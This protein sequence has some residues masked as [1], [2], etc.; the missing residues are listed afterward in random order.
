MNLFCEIGLIVI[1]LLLLLLL[2]L[3][4]FYCTCMFCTSLISYK[5]RTIM[6]INDP[7]TLFWVGGKVG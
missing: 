3:L 2:L 7:P 1:I 4:L 6:L 5:K